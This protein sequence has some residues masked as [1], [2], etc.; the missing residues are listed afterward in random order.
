MSREIASAAIPVARAATRGAKGVPA[1]MRGFEILDTV[2]SSDQPKTVSTL[3]QQLALPKSTVHGLC[4]TLVALGL[5]IRREDNSFRL[6]PHVMRWANAFLSRTDLTAEFASLW[7]D[8][9][10]FTNETITLSVLDGREVVYVGCRNSASPLGITFRI[11]MRLPAVFTATGKAILSAMSEAEV[12]C[13]LAGPWPESPTSRSVTG[14]G[15]L[16]RELRQTRKR[17]FS[18][19]DGQTREGMYCFGSVVRDSSNLA[20]AGVAVSLLASAAD[21]RTVELAGK[22]IQTIAA[23][24]SRRLGAD[25]A[26]HV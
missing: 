13:L 12:R 8:L 11:G 14:I 9:H 7:D 21:R 10:V 3:A 1:L 6:G 18:I 2:A 5:L 15:A 17:G 22:S 4:T 20:I 26:K 19:D 16:F 25:V 23:Q 24:L